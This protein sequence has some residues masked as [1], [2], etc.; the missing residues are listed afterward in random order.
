VYSAGSTYSIAGEQIEHH[1]GV[2]AVAASLGL[3][4]YVLAY[5][6][7]DLLFAPLSETPVI[8]RNPVYWAPFIII[9]GSLI[10]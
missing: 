9:W 1:F 2:S 5:G 8:G 7:G 3:G 4:L 6:I 10:S